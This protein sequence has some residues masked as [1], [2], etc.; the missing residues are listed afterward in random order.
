M[1]PVNGVGVCG[2]TW[3]CSPPAISSV[4]MKTVTGSSSSSLHLCFTVAQWG[5]PGIGIESRRPLEIH[6]KTKRTFSFTEA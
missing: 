1:F 2:G 6:E 3:R 5:F 4:T